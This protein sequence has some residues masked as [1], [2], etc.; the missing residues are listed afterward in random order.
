MYNQAMDLRK[1]IEEYLSKAYLM[2][3]ATTDNNQPWV[4]S[5]YFAYD[6]S[7]NLYWISR[8]TRRHSKELR[9]NE[10]V[11]GTVVLPH[12]HGEKVRGLQFEGVAKELISKEAIKEIECYSNRFQDIPKEKIKTILEGKDSHV[13]YKISPTLFI[14]FDEVNFPD[15]PRQELPIV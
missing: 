2:Q 6:E 15:N 3:V 8:P 13:C 14:L 9:S 1:L 12:T 4:C 10:R 11:A 7:L 5:V